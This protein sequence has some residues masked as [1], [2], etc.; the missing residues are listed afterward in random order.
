MDWFRYLHRYGTILIYTH[1]GL[2]SGPADQQKVVICS[3]EAIPGCTSDTPAE[4][5]YEAMQRA[6]RYLEDIQEGRVGWFVASKTKEKLLALAYYCIFPSFIERWSTQFARDLGGQWNCVVFMGGCS[7]MGEPE[8]ADGS[9]PANTTMAGAFCYTTNNV[10][11]YGWRGTVTD[12]AEAR[13]MKRLYELLLE[14]RLS[15][16]EAYRGL[17]QAGYTVGEYNPGTALWYCYHNDGENLVLRRTQYGDLDEDGRVTVGDLAALTR[18]WK[19]AQ[20]GDSDRDPR[21]DTDSDWD[22]DHEDVWRI[23]QSLELP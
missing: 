5:V 4:D 22:L 13:A 17:Q 18:S 16:V 2:T 19:Q 7:T 21:A 12:I 9:P 8:G 23:L 15:A 1:G 14:S 11:Y 20:S 3:G 10:M 6:G